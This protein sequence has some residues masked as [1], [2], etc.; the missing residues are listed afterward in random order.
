ML[1]VTESNNLHSS[2]CAALSVWTAAS[3]SRAA[4]FDA[5]MAADLGLSKADRQ[6][7]YVLFLAHQAA[8]RVS[9]AARQS[10]DALR[11]AWVKH[12][13]EYRESQD[14]QDYSDECDVIDESNRRS[15]ELEDTQ[16]SL[17]QYGRTESPSGFSV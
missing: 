3:A 15:L 6:D 17:F 1:T 7:S 14:Y 9:D 8:C 2:Y 5:Y 13:D 4:A 12:R 16:L 11:Q 10:C